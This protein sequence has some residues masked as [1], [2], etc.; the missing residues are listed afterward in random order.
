M[1]TQNDLLSEKFAE[2]ADE[3]LRLEENFRDNQYIR[4]RLA[5]ARDNLNDAY[6][7]LHLLDLNILTS[8]STDK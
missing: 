1:K 5:A 6:S 7:A 4:N 8:I 3:I 2:L